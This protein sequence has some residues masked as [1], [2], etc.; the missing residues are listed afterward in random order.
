VHKAEPVI[1]RPG[2]G[3]R[4]PE[5]AG[6]A[7][8]IRIWNVAGLLSLDLQP[9]T[10]LECSVYVELPVHALLLWPEVAG[11]VCH[12]DHLGPVDLVGVPI[13]HNGRRALAEHVLQP[14]GALTVR[15][16]DQEAVSML[17]RDDRGLIRPAR[18][19]ADMADD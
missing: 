4:A 14:I 8:W 1:D 17:G 2:H 7:M 15:E 10:D 12:R 18:S 13:G 16:G 9:L 6:A 5:L 3:L 19:P 11:G